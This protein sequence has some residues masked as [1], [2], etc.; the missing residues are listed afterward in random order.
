MARSVPLIVA[1][2]TFSCILTK[3]RAWAVKSRH[4]SVELFSF[5]DLSLHSHFWNSP[6]H[7]RCNLRCIVFFL[8]TNQLEFPPIWHAEC[9][10]NRG[11]SNDGKKKSNV[12]WKIYLSRSSNLRCGFQQLKPFL[13]WR[14][15]SM[16]TESMKPRCWL[17]GPLHH[18]ICSPPR[19]HRWGLP[20][21]LPFR[22]Y[23]RS[24]CYQHSVSRIMFHARSHPCN[25]RTE[26]IENPRL[27]SVRRALP[28]LVFFRLSDSRIWIRFLGVAKINFDFRL[29]SLF[30][31]F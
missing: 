16:N 20:P 23:R 10:T 21:L 4:A 3:Y 28:C 22:H 1:G 31:W 14:Q 19:C 5:W 9:K 24:V 25:L 11:S 27:P 30:G 13:Y 18:H 7:A 6:C 26:D 29:G 15:R 8:S 12:I 2:T 17:I